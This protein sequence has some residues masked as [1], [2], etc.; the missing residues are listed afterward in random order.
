MTSEKEQLNCYNK[1]CGKQFTKEQ[2]G[3]DVCEFH[4]GGP[5]F[6]D[7]YKGWSCC[8]KRTT[9]FTEFLNIKG[10]TKG[11]HNPE[12]P[13]PQVQSVE[14]NYDDDDVSIKKEPKPPREPNP[15]KAVERPRSDEQMV[16][17]PITVGA[18][19]K[20]AIAKLRK[21][22]VSATENANSDE[23]QLGTCCKRT[24]CGK[25]YEGQESKNEQCF[26]HAGTAVFHEGMKYW[27]CCQKK[28]SNF[29]DFLKQPGCT[30]G[31]HLWIKAEENNSTAVCRH[32]WHQ[33][34]SYAVLTVYCK[35]ADPDTSTIAANQV[36]LVLSIKYDGGRGVFKKEIT[37]EGAIDPARSSVKMLGT[38]V[39]IK[40][41]K[42]EAFSWKKFEIHEKVEQ[43][44]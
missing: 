15:V 22:E 34:A 17:I 28:T 40:L 43:L 20:D 3:P 39:E 18:T 16:P 14:S 42:M 44:E 37:L 1:G 24:S 36:Q 13:Q 4:P 11:Y 30:K 26:Y 8:K 19:L 5:I 35:V 41:R 7:A 33:T 32:D 29:D 31:V 10:C 27:S 6:H 2:D 25:A 21:M 23:I 38:K 12:K 9:D